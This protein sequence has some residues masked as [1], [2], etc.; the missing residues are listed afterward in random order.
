MQPSSIRASA[1]ALC[2]LAGLTTACEQND[3]SQ[4]DPSNS[5]PSAA[6]TRDVT[7]QDTATAINRLKTTRPEASRPETSEASR[8]AAT[9]AN[10]P[11]LRSRS[12]LPALPR[13]PTLTPPALP[14]MPSL[15][16]LPQ[17]RRLSTPAIA[18]NSAPNGP[19]PTAASDSSNPAAPPL[20]PTS[21]SAAG[22]NPNAINAAAPAAIARNPATPGTPSSQSSDIQGHWS[23]PL[24]TA[25][26]QAGIIQGFMDGNFRPD[27][28][29]TQEQFLSMVK[30]AFPDEEV[31]PETVPLRPGMTRAEAAKVIYQ[32]LA[33]QGRVAP[34]ATLVATQ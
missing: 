2:A 18:Q 16:H 26:M 9:I 11:A 15:W 13:I 24:V 14:L 34:L 7:V 30:K 8:L 17:T 1:I 3:F 25:L 33:D 23:Q 10:L 32:A 31:R 4:S 28:P 20:L 21:S 6:S 27:Q 12:A 22:A 19:V 5:E 29:I